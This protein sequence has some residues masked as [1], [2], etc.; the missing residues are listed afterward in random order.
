M[1][2]YP[3]IYSLRAIWVSEASPTKT[4]EQV[5]KLASLAQ[6]GERRGKPVHPDLENSRFSYVG[7][8]LYSTTPGTV[9]KLLNDLKWPTLEKRRRVE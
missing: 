8:L 9:T 6:I 7:F 4:R 1:K 2:T 5:A 3:K